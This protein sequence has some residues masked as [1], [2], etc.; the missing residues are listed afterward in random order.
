MAGLGG[1]LRGSGGMLG[2]ISGMEGAARSLD[3]LA[4]SAE[5]GT[6]VLDRLDSEVGME[7]LVGALD[8]LERLTAAAE[9]LRGSVAG[10]HEGMRRIEERMAGL[11]ARLGPP[12]DGLAPRPARAR[13]TPVR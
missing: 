5:R 1:L 11:E 7:R 2:Q 8:L 3:R 9:E 6:R 12:P 10:M 4:H 13:T